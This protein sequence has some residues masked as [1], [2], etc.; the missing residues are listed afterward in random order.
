[1]LVSGIIANTLN[2][3]PFFAAPLLAGYGPILKIR[4]VLNAETQ[5]KEM[6]HAKQM[7]QQLLD[8]M[9]RRR[10]L[11]SL[12]HNE[13][14]PQDVSFSFDGDSELFPSLSLGIEGGQ[15]VALHSSPCLGKRTILQLIAQHLQPNHGFIHF[16]CSW[17]IW[18]VDSIPTLL[19][20]TLMYN[21]RFG[22][23]IK[24]TDSEIWDLCSY[25]HFHPKLTGK[26]DMWV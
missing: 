9:A 5:S 20:C 26:G 12:A 1:M 11:R 7:R 4:N 6:F 24:H 21:L 17:R 22:G 10:D 16:P 23:I 19:N 25:L 2:L 18:Y 8:R 15:V 14:R 13:L 3:S